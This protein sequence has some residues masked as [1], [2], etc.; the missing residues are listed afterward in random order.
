M[1]NDNWIVPSRRTLDDVLAGRAKEGFERQFIRVDPGP[2]LLPERVVGWEVLHHAEHQPFELDLRRVHLHTQPPD[3]E[4]GREIGFSRFVKEVR[5]GHAE[6]VLGFNALQAILQNTDLIPDDWLIPRDDG[7]FE[8]ILFLG[9]M[10][11]IHNYGPGC[12]ALR[13]RMQGKKVRWYRRWCHGWIMFN[14]ACIAAMLDTSPKE[15]GL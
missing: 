7:G 14:R 15:L 4:T 8:D 6:R 12:P 5:E 10:V 1:K 9:T 3:E 2:P 11:M 13:A